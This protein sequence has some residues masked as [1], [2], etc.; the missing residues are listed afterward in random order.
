MREPIATRIIHACGMP[1][2]AADLRISPDFVSGGNGSHRGGKAGARRCRNGPPRHHRQ[3]SLNVICTLNDPRA[4]EIGIA[5]GN[6]RSAAAVE[7]WR[8]HLDGAIVVIGNAPTALFALLEMI[9][10]GAPRPAAIVG[11]P[12][13]FVGAAEIKDELAANPRG[14][15]FAT[16]LGRKG[17]SAMAAAV[18]N[19]PDAGHGMTQ[20]AH[21]RRHGR[22]RL[23]RPV[24]QGPPG[25]RDGGGD[26]RLRPPP[27]LP[28]GNTR[29]NSTNGRSPS[30]PSSSASRPLRG[31]R[32]VILATGDPLNY[33][34]ARKLMEF[35]PFAEMEIIPHLSAFSLAAARVG[36][37]L[38]DC[39][40]L[41]LHGRDA[42][43]IE[44]FIQPDVRLIVLTA[45]A[46]TI[47]EVARR[48]V[49]R[50]F[51]RAEI[52][53]LENMGGAR[54]RQSAFIADAP[55]ASDYLRPQHAGDPLHRLSGRE[56][57]LAPRGPPRRSLRA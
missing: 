4:R 45:D 37:S 49:A 9:D 35:I 52:T 17:G 19:A 3:V 23:G 21:H 16:L 6:T 41:T 14:I 30:R 22:G 38:P 29:R 44:A 13:G 54:E 32:T 53:V 20:V 33:G 1:E 10:A 47:P 5:T 27:R 24:G 48:L 42:A 51:G 34:V 55:A 8:P 26:R 25:H 36:W 46:T 7:L 40:T 50:G 56:D 28:A 39:D 57:L 15:P 18:I 12:V 11:F 31:R 43:N 2:I